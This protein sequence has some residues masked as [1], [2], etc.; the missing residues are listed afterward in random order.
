MPKL[1]P[2]LKDY[3][4]GLGLR[5]ELLHVI[6][7]FINTVCLENAMANPTILLDSDVKDPAALH[8]LMVDGQGLALSKWPR[9][10][11]NTNLGQSQPSSFSGQKGGNHI[12][13]NRSHNFVLDQPKFSSLLTMIFFS[14]SASR[15]G[16]PLLEIKEDE[17]ED[18]RVIQKGDPLT[19]LPPPSSPLFSLFLLCFISWELTVRKCICIAHDTSGTIRFS[20]TEYVR[21]R[22]IVTSD[23]YVHIGSP[24]STSAK[25]A[26]NIK[27][28][29]P[30]VAR[31]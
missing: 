21:L 5:Q 2:D 12:L 25:E 3:Y 30:P 8:K 23:T 14:E 4:L 13:E 29:I 27:Y 6:Y 17:N 20:W 15:L 9:Y 19:T 31:L 28:R 22:T 26:R 1:C 24:F 10:K 7:D 11:G 16:H 18:G